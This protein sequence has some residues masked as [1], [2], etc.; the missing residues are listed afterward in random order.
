[1]EA[2]DYV[3]MDPTMK[4]KWLAGLREGN[5]RQGQQALR[6]KDNTYCCLGVLADVC[7][8][9]WQEPHEGDDPAYFFQDEFTGHEWAGALPSS[10]PLDGNATGK[11]I[12]MNDNG[13]PF[14]EI[15]AW[16]EANL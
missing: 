10:I 2:Y 6:R 9:K 16:I 13:A 12:F 1:M 4:A 5:Y 11:L 15:A 8:V 14:S 7:G 3:K